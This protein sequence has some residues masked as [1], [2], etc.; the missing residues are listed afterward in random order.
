MTY[1]ERP[2]VIKFYVTE[3]EENFIN[4][5]MSLMKT[6]NRSA[7]LRKMAMDGYILNVDY[8]MFRDINSSLQRIGSNINQ[9]LK[10]VNVTGNIY[11]EDVENIK[12][13]QEEVWQL[14]RFM[15]SKLP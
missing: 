1:R 14:Q 11:Q 6:K 8:S 2:K 12:A 4:K 13:K 15:L 10:R 5:K 3:E 7:Y 9:L